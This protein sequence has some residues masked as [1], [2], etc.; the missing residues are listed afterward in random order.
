MTFQSSA[1]TD[2]LQWLEAIFG[3]QSEALS[4]HAQ[5]SKGTLALDLNL[6]RAR[7]NS[8]DL[9]KAEV[10]ATWADQNVMWSLRG[11][12]SA[13]GLLTMRGT[14]A[15]VPAERAPATWGQAWVPE[16]WLSFDGR[17]SGQMGVGGSISRPSLQGALAQTGRA[18]GYNM[19][20]TYRFEWPLRILPDLGLWTRPKCAMPWEIRPHGPPRCTTRRFAT[21]TSTCPYSMSRPSHTSAVT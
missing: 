13:D 8:V 20:G 1:G 3:L 11:S 18:L 19:G 2:A 16:T 7:W 4:C 9:A 17:V 14:L 10:A 21:S 12:D 6:D 5:W 15:V